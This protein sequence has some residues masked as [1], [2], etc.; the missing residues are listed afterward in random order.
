MMKGW[1]TNMKKTTR[2]LALLLGLV[3]CLSLAA[4]GNKTEPAAEGGDAPAAPAEAAAPA[5]E[6][7]AEGLKVFRYGTDANSTTFDPASDLQTNSGSFLVHAVGESL[8]TCDPDGNMTPKLASEVEYT[9]DTLTIKLREGVKFSNG[10]DMTAADVLFT[11]RH[12]AAQL[13]TAAMYA[14]MD[15][16]NA[17]MPDDYTLVIPMNYYDAALIDLL[18]NASC[19]IL[20]ENVAG[21]EGYT[22][23]WLIGTGPYML[24]GDGVSDTSGWEE[25]VK[26]TLV[27]NPYYWGEAPYYDELQVYFYS[28]ESTRYADFQAGNLDAAYLTQ[29]TYINNL[30]NG[31]V[32]DAELITAN[33]NSVYCFEMAVVLGGASGEPEVSAP[34]ADINIR[35][36]FAHCLDVPTMVETLG[37]GVY[38]TASSL[39]GEGSWVYEDL[40]VYEYDPELAAQYLAE[41]G[42]SVDNPIEI[43]VYA[44][45]TAWS[46]ALFE[47]AQSYAAKIGINL[48]LAGV[49]DFATILPK[50]IGGQ[51]PMSFGQ[52]SNGSGNDPANLLQQFGPASDNSLLRVRDPKLGELFTE[53]ASCTDKSERQKIYQDMIRGMYESYHVVPVC[54]GTVNFAVRSEHTSFASSIDTSARLDPTL[55]TD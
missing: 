16:A 53:G 14:C 20:D 25:S 31:A 28:E 40:G 2:L 32:A 42:Y 17:E 5:Q 50:L 36:A 34:F 29:A 11:F 3:L 47:A 45:G 27:R 35:K 33:E 13:R 49:T 30:A 7:T 23:N 38:A 26:Y 8:W 46:L 10:D 21:A 4:C 6:E 19:L 43:E 18:G 52:G 44:E 22:F 54:V 1:T 48:N 37:E 9:E 12:V 55:L 15:L 39:V 24:K 51:V 41:A